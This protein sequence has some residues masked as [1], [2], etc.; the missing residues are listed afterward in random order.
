MIREVYT[1]LKLSLE[2]K[3]I[4]LLAQSLWGSKLK[5]IE[6]FKKNPEKSIL[7]GTDT[8]WEGIDIPGEDLQYLIIHKIPF[9]VPT[10][11]IF[12][13]RS[14][15]YTDSF[16]QYAIPKS[17][18]KLKQGFWRLIRSKKDTWVVVFLDDRIFSTSWGKVYI[19]A[20]P[21]EVKIL[22]GSSQ[23]LLE[24]LQNKE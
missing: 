20:F 22:Y 21:K 12:I 7:I 4:E 11:P 14:K 9:Q 19:D 3:N 5:Q 23:K 15:L 17:L 6:A 10:D 18:I 13:A 24:V 1:N 8:F 2:E 16:S